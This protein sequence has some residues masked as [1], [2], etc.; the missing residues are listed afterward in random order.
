MF[1]V[2]SPTANRPDSVSCVRT[3]GIA[4]LFDAVDDSSTLFSWV[5]VYI[6]HVN[7]RNEV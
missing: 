6:H 7:L 3:D 5:Q 2:V 4:V 1:P